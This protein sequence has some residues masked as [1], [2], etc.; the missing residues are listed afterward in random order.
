MAS[1]EA[2]GGP[3]SLM[4]Q[5]HWNVWT[6]LREDAKD[7]ARLLALS[8]RR[9]NPRSLGIEGFALQHAVAL[10]M[11]CQT[12]RRNPSPE[13]PYPMLPLP[14]ELGTPKA[15]YDVEAAC[16]TIPH[17]L[18][19][20]KH[21][22]LHLRTV[23]GYRSHEDDRLRWEPAANP[24]E[25]YTDALL[26]VWHNWLWDTKFAVPHSTEAAPEPDRTDFGQSSELALASR[27]LAFGL[28]LMLDLK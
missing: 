2:E 8:R 17:L 10:E 18:P 6:Q 24:E 3:K 5:A 20:T 13:L 19:Y 15:R 22:L 12:A 7:T 11:R 1:N 4:P 27:R 26:A 23:F 21:D 25:K 14:R 16:C 9:T 28:K